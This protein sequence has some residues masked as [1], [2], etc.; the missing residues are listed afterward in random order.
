MSR[1]APRALFGVHGVTPYNRTTGLPYGELRVLKGSSLSLQGEQQELMGGASKYAWA[2]EEGAISAELSLNVG[3]LE[4]FMFELF[5]GKAPTALSAEATGNVS[6]AVNK[7]GTTIING[8]NGISAVAA[9]ASDVIVA[10]AA[11]TFDL[12]LLSSIDTA[13]GNNISFENDAMKLNASPLDIS[14]ATVVHAATGLTFTKAGTPAF[15]VGD[16]ATFEV[17]PVNGGGSTVTIGSSSDTNFPEF[18]ALVYAQKRGNQEM[19]EIDI[20]RCKAAGMPL[21]F[22]MGAF[23]GFE[24]KVKCLYDETLDGVFSFRH[25][26]PT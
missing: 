13:R 26:K 1:S 11:G 24:V 12:Y 20:F 10:T 9:T 22:E 5:L 15:T 17:R 3:Q 23:A 2:V 6:T 4:D 14:S 7:K 19:A 16:T 8:T 25:V 21:P 18:G